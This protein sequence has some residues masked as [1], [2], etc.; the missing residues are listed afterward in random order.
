VKLKLLVETKVEEEFEVEFPIFRCV[1]Y[2]NC[3]HYTRINADL[4]ADTVVVGDEFDEETGQPLDD[5]ITLEYEAKY[6]F[7]GSSV[8]YHLGRDRYTLSERDFTQIL[9]K[10]ADALAAIMRRTGV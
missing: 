10:A 4:S 7:D 1:K 2:C 3:T 6:E 8:D 5:A 9:Q